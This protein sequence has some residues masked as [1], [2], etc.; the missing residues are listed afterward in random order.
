MTEFTP[1]VAGRVAQAALFE[2]WRRQIVAGHLTEAGLLAIRTRV[3]PESKE[4]PDDMQ[5][6]AMRLDV[7]RALGM[8]SDDIPHDVGGLD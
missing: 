6:D 1:E 7:E 2:E 3:T 5:R 4:F 8:G